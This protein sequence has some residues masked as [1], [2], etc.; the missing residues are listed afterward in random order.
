MQVT[1]SRWSIRTLSPVVAARGI[2]LAFASSGVAWLCAFGGTPSLPRAPLELGS[3]ARDIL[4]NHCAACHTPDSNSFA[5]VRYKGDFDAVLDFARL[6]EGPY[7]DLKEPEESE[8]YLLV[9][10]EEMPPPKAVASGHSRVLSASERATLLAWIRSGAPDPAAAGPVAPVEQGQADLERGE[11]AF[12]A[13]CTACHPASR[14][15]GKS[16][17]FDGWVQTVERMAQKPGARVDTD[18]TEAIA[19]FLEAHSA[20]RMTP[21]SG[22]TPSTNDWW[23]ALQVHLTV[24]TMWRDSGSGDRVENADFV[25]ELWGSVE[26]HQQD[27]PFS[28]RVSACTTCH[29]GFDEGAGP[30]ETV[31]AAMRV[32]LA[33]ALNTQ[34]S[35]RAGLEAGRF[36]VPFGSFSSQ[37]NPAAYRTVTRPLLYN[38]GQLVD[39]RDIGPAILPMPYSDEGFKADVSSQLGGDVSADFDFYVVNGLQGD[40]GVNFFQSR[41]YTDNNSDPAFGGRLAVGTPAFSVGASAMTGNLEASGSPERLGYDVM[42]LDLNAR[43]GRRVRVV[44]EVARRSNDIR[45]FVASQPYGNVDLEG[46]VIESDVVLS[47]SRGISFIARLDATRYEGT[48]SPIVSSLSSDF[49]VERFTWGFDFAV[50]GN[51]NLMLNHEHWSMPESLDDVDVLGLRWVIAF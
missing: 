47:Q 13:A 41:S 48:V 50:F 26:W 4:R 25:A 28:A 20:Q 5:D 1:P 37:A 8:L 10:E 2:A 29:E 16:K 7:L 42:G 9:A 17:T 30:I 35:M 39:R 33:K 31:E 21:E 14:A 11:D 27:G 15:L 12:Y 36:I 45:T 3:E 40:F 23:E 24:S 51:S 18:E 22:A 49:R 32:D 38:M 19:A 6:R 44:A 46:Y 43:F 34:G